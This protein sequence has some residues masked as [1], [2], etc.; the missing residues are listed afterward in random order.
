MS[1]ESSAFDTGTGIEAGARVGPRGGR[2][3]N[4]EVGYVEGNPRAAQPS[5]SRTLPK[6][7]PGKASAG[8]AR[9]AGIP[10]T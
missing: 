1:P 7:R 2:A 10:A 3:R 8:I 6:R 4:A 5:M 9:R